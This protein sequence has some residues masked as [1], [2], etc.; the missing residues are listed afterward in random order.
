MVIEKIYDQKKRKIKNYPCKSN[1]ASSLGDPCL[2]RLVYERTHWQEK[3]LH[4][5][6]LQLIFDEGNN[7]EQVVLRDLQNSG[8]EIYEQQRAFE[9]KDLNITGH[10]DLKLMIDGNLIPTEIKSMSPWI[11]D[12]VNE[13]KDFYNEKYPWLHKYPAQLTLYMLDS[14]E[15]KGLFI[16]KN[17]STGQLKE[18]W[19]ELDWDL[20]DKLF[21]KAKLINNHIAKNTIPDRIKNV[22]LCE[23]CPFNHICLPDKDYGNGFYVE[24]HP[25]IEQ[26]L[27]KH[28]ELK[29]YNKEYNSIDS[30]LKKLLTGKTDLIIGNWAI[31]G[32][33]IDRKSTVIPAYKYWNRKVKAIAKQQK[34][35]ASA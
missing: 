14:N 31:S 11:F 4:D 1:R 20:G 17:K 12:S 7:Q 29:I 10:L 15:E 34:Q 21:H 32:E 8:F 24:D 2:R 23:K 28:A 25:E 13:V 22:D 5:I 18:V 26:L 30:R 3:Q 9:I 16:L 27:N 33:W 35:K 19:L 6:G